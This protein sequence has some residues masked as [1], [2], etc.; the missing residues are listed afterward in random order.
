MVSSEID[1]MK[2]ELLV[3]SL[4]KSGL[5]GDDCDWFTCDWFACDWFTV[6]CDWFLLRLVPMLRLVLMLRPILFPKYPSDS[7]QRLVVPNEWS[8]PTIVYS[9]E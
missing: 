8:Y 6:A 2:S 9:N 5:I 3:E 4:I 7:F 1:A